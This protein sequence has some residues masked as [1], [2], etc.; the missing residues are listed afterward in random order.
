MTTPAKQYQNVSYKELIQYSTNNPNRTNKLDSIEIIATKP[1][2][3]TSLNKLGLK[4]YR[5]FNLNPTGV[6]SL[7]ACI[8]DPSYYSLSS[9]NVRTQTII[10]LATSLQ[11]ET[12]TMKNTELSRKR[13][14]VHDLI[15]ASYN[16]SQ[17]EE[18]DYLDLFHGISFMRNIHFILMK[19]AIQE[20]V[21][22]GT[23]SNSALKGEIVF[24]SDPVCWKKEN[25][26]WIADYRARWVA[27]PSEQESQDL[28]TFLATWISTIE[29][30][31]WIIQWP[32]IEATKT[33]L[34]EQLSTLPT[35]QV[36]DKKLTKEILSGRLSRA[37]T[38]QLFTQWMTRID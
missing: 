13:R 27:V 19:E 34:V 37:K 29:Q 17:L 23:K 38:I 24:S 7:M 18:K 3:D 2:E 8:A 36:T 1:A 14:K 10:E 28:H 21:E 30:Q 26:V 12:E 4:G 20:G 5:A 15:G 9:K 6:L 16:G 35:W 33:E 25:P 31:G 32:T 22:E 11:E